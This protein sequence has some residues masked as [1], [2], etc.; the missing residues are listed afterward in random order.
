[1][2]YTYIVIES[3][4]DKGD[5][6]ILYPK[7]CKLSIATYPYLTTMLENLL[8]EE[9]ELT[10]GDK[11]IQEDFQIKECDYWTQFDEYFK[12]FSRCSTI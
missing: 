10:I 4:W 5:Y 12:D 8:K 3:H 11:K 9:K 2:Q 1:M 6:K 7:A